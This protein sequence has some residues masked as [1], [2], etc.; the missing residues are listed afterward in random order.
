MSIWFIH[1]EGLLNSLGPSRKKQMDNTAR[2]A[3]RKNS[4][5]ASQFKKVLQALANNAL[6]DSDV[7]SHLQRLLKSGAM[8]DVLRAV[9]QR[10][11]SI[12]PLP[13]YAHTEILRFLN[14]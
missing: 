2:P 8:P 3:D 9:L 13:A 1:L 10:Y 5:S 11:D 4:S 12:E 7:E 14:E 6:P